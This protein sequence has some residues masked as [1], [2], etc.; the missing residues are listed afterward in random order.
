[1]KYM[2]CRKFW[3]QWSRLNE[4]MLVCL[5]LFGFTTA[6]AAGDLLVAPTR[7]LFDGSRGTEVVLNNIGNEVATYRVSLELRRMTPDGQLEEVTTPNAT[8]QTALS[9]ISYA[10]R[11]VTLAPNQPQA[12][13]IGVRPPPNLPP[14][15]YRAH[16]LFRA[17]P[18]VA[19]VPRDSG[20]QT[21]VNIALT[22]IY[23]VS[24]PVIVRS[25]SLQATARISDAALVKDEEG[26]PAVALTLNREGNR[27][28]YGEIRISRPGDK[29]PFLLVRGIA[30]YPEITSRK[31][32]LSIP[33]DAVGPFHGPATIQ[34]IADQASGG[35]VIAETRVVLR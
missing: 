29:K 34:Y 22:P 19:P 17:I 8:E 5:G 20:Q 24:I 6:Q 23:G 33:D 35:G 2:K 7:I 26:Q 1:M 9:M 27:S 14:G 18:A 32:V 28:V 13:R 30:V 25:G 16:M 15:E 31:V 10:P 12:I 11:R 3:R 4:M 21:G